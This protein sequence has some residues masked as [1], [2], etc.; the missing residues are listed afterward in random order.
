M[1]VVAQIAD[2][3][4]AR[5]FGIPL[6]TYTHEV[7]SV[8]SLEPAWG[9]DERRRLSRCGTDHLVFFLVDDTTRLLCVFLFAFLL[10]TS[11]ELNLWKTQ[12]DVWSVGAIFA[13]MASGIPLF[14]GDSEIDEIFRIFRCVSSPSDRPKSRR[15]DPIS[16]RNRLLGTPNT[17]VWPGLALMPDFKT[18][19][20]Q[21]RP[22]HLGEALP[23]MDGKALHLLSGMLTYDPARRISGAPSLLPLKAFANPKS[24]SAKSSLLH[25]YFHSTDG[26]PTDPLLG[27]YNPSSLLCAPP[28]PRAAQGLMAS[29]II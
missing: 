25:P 22:Q 29:P 8:A 17:Q 28:P 27:S 24:L 9:A 20:P 12:V 10:A 11:S 14:P 1:R 5:A 4:L 16:P 15:T 23:E 3:G 18:T 13:E 21:W 2:F 6:R 19:F 7:R 26:R